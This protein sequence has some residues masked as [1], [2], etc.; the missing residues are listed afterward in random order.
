MVTVEPGVAR[1]EL[2]EPITALD[3]ATKLAPFA[4]TRSSVWNM[5]LETMVS[6][7]TFPSIVMAAASALAM[8]KSKSR[9]AGRQLSDRMPN[10]V[11][12]GI[13]LT[14]CGFATG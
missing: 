4:R 6:G 14:G 12:D 8:P 1:R 10:R 2:T 3:S 9:I 7:V 5:A 11:T 13:R